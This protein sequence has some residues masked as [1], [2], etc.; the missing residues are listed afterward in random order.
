M[1]RSVDQNGARRALRARF[2]GVC[3]GRARSTS[4]ASDIAGPCSAARDAAAH[5]VF[6]ARGVER[7]AACPCWR[8]ARRG[9][10]VLPLAPAQAFENEAERRRRHELG[11][12]LRRLVLRL[13]PSLREGLGPVQRA[14]SLEDDAVRGARGL[15]GLDPLFRE[16]REARLARGLERV[17]ARHPGGGLVHARERRS[18]G[19]RAE[20]DPQD[21]DNPVGHRE[22]G[23]EALGR[24]RG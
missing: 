1:E 8:A 17:D 7:R 11:H 13:E 22:L 10:S 18:E 9:A 23:P 6:A 2:Q 20:L 12:Q 4:C 24:R 3:P 16:G 15:V 5:R 14:P 21:V 19:I